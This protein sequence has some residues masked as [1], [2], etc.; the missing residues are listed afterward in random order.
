MTDRWKL[1]EVRDGVVLQGVV[2]QFAACVGPELMRKI[3]LDL[4]M[5]GWEDD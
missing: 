2:A 3:A 5:G 1:D 4:G